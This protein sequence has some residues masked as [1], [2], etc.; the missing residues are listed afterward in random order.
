LVFF[1][2]FNK[3]KCIENFVKQRHQHSGV[4]EKVE[5]CLLS[6]KFVAGFLVTMTIEEN[7]TYG[8]GGIAL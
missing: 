4:P 6:G 5:R 8:D 7:W 3:K 1:F 2:F